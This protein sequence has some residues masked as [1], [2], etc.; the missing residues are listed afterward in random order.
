MIRLPLLIGL[1]WF[2][3]A[4]V[5]AEPSRAMP[6]PEPE[7]AACLADYA[8]SHDGEAYSQ[9]IA[10]VDHMKLRRRWC[11]STPDPDRCVAEVDRL[12]A[13]ERWLS[14]HL[15][16]PE[17]AH[18]EAAAIAATILYRQHIIDLIALRL[19]ALGF[20]VPLSEVAPINQRWEVLESLREIDAD[21][22]DAYL[23]KLEEG[24]VAFEEYTPTLFP[25]AKFGDEQRRDPV[26]GQND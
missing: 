9:C 15:P 3:G 7:V 22:A 6:E 26:G 2:A 21:A 24:K 18:V 13:W 17:H 8:D 1:A 19:A 11:Q 5:A 14:W 10:E 25:W 23:S 12:G 16:Q 20:E 4:P